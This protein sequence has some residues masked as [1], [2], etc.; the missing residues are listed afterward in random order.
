MTDWRDELTSGVLRVAVG[1]E[2]VDEY[3]VGVADGPGSEPCGP[4]TRF[5]IAS[6]SK[7]FTAAA[8]LVLVQ[9]GLLATGDKLAR[10]FPGGPEGWADITVHHLLSHTSGLGHWEDFPGIDPYAP[11]PAGQLVATVKS[12]PLIHSP[13]SCFYYSSQGLWL[14]AQIVEQVSERPYAEFVGS[15][16]LEPAGLADTFVGS[17]GQRPRVA[18]GHADGAPVP[19]Y[20]LDHTSKGAGDVYST[21]TD[22]NR[23]HR[24]LVDVLDESSRQMMFTPWVPTGDN[25]GIWAPDDAHGYGCYIGHLGPLERRYH[26]GHN[27]GFNSISAWVPERDL[28]LAVTG[29]DDPIDPLA[30]ARSYLAANPSLL[31]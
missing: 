16:V 6:I 1:G 18:T 20:E 15:A 10:W 2:V 25:P 4:R 24:H 26:S 27:A 17:A 29:N 13:G 8:V 30:V 12:R 23:W 31:A 14:L 21:V 11:M 7:Q 3:C 5:Q 22:L 9:R 28:S 19:S